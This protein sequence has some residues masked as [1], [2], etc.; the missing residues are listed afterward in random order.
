MK[1]IQDWR[2]RKCEWAGL[3]LFS[4]E[5][6]LVVHHV[7]KYLSFLLQNEYLHKY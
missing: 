1:T 5:K 2:Q 4:K 3:I 7:K 6:K